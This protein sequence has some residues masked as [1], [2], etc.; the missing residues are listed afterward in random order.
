LTRTGLARDGGPDREIDRP[1]SEDEPE[2][3]KEE[4]PGFIERTLKWASP[5]VMVLHLVFTG[6][7]VKRVY[8]TNQDIPIHTP[9]D[10]QGIQ[11]AGWCA[12]SR[13]PRSY[14]L[15]AEAG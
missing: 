8:F 6:F 2:K 4:K 7:M 15:L 13:L 1:Q 11:E 14:I 3:E 12:S 9:A 10:F 5:Y